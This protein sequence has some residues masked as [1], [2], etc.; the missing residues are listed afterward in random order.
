[1]ADQSVG[2]HGV[3]AAAS[4]PSVLGFI[5]I[6]ELQSRTASGAA[7]LVLVAVADYFWWHEGWWANMLFT[8]FT[9]LTLAAV[10]VAVSRRVFFAAIVTATLVTLIVVASSVKRQL[11]DMVVNASSRS[12]TT[13]RPLAPSAARTAAGPS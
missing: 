1:M 2:Q 6:R 13:R 11:M 7:G 10:L 3:P 9:T 8:L 5:G 12:V 4:R